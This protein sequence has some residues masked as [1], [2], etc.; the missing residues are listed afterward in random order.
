MPMHV[1]ASNQPNGS[2]PA[3]A[4][5]A[6]R[7]CSRSAI[8]TRPAP[9]LLRIAQ[10]APAASPIWPGC[11]WRAVDLPPAWSL[12]VLVPAAGAM[13]VGAT[14]LCVDLMMWMALGVTWAVKTYGCQFAQQ[15]SSCLLQ[16][17]HQS[18]G[19]QVKCDQS[20]AG[21]RREGA[22]ESCMNDLGTPVHV[23]N[24]APWCSSLPGN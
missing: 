7:R 20:Q 17:H 18:T 2:A 11:P 19:S 13:G 14:A 4:R 9:L 12:R 16:T 8:A 24:H 1:Q 23:S 5:R 10:A 6:L 3:A 15:R 21:C 22:L